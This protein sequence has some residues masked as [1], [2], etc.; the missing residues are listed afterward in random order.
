MTR[1]E[2]EVDGSLL[3][4]TAADM[5]HAIDI[6][7]TARQLA[8]GPSRRL[9]GWHRRLVEDQRSQNAGT[10]GADR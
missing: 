7:G 5:V 10:G 8:F 6:G 4:L 9:P 1:P 3:A 2:L